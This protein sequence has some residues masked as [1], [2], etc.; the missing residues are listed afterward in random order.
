MKTNTRPVRKPRP[1]WEDVIQRGTSQIL[2]IRGR[3]KQA[4]DRVMGVSSEGGQGPEGAA[5]GMEME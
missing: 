4:E 2:G 1:R 3:R 5:D